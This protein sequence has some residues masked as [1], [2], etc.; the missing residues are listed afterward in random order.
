[1]NSMPQQP[2]ARESTWERDQVELD[3]IAIA[4]EN[5]AIFYDPDQRRWDPRL[6]SA[7]RELLRV[8]SRGHR[9]S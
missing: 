6:H 8:G 5:C 4:M 7:A 3:S 9:L 1:M 2:N